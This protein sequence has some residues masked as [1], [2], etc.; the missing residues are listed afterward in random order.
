MNIYSPTPQELGPS[1]P[2]PVGTSAASSADPSTDLA[3]E[4]GFTQ[5]MLDERATVRAL[6]DLTEIGFGAELIPGVVA[7][8]LSEVSIFRSMRLKVP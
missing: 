8:H 3:A 5:T 2:V 6:E 7:K 4:K 1:A